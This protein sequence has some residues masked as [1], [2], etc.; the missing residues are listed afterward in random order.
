[1]GRTLLVSQTF[2]KQSLLVKIV[3]DNQ[4]SIHHNK[5]V[6]HSFNTNCNVVISYP[7][8]LVK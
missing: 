7:M 6:F 3:V 5:H 8:D 1:M 4:L 2:K